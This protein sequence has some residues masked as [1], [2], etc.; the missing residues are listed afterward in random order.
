MISG[1]KKIHIYHFKWNI[2][3]QNGVFFK[4]LEGPFK[5][6]IYTISSG[7]SGNKTRMEV[8]NRALKYKP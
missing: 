4:N 7:T 6:D 8:T 2:R 5:I 1:F 3:K